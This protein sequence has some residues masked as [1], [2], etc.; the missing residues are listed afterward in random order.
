MTIPDEEIE[1]MRR[2]DFEEAINSVRLPAE[3]TVTRD[4]GTNHVAIANSKN[5][6]VT[7]CYLFNLKM[8]LSHIADLY[9]G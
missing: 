7:V 6:N 4:E 9:G 8:V 2:R 1:E 3:L 5:G